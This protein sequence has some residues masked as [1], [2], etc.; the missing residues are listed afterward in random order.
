MKKKKN[1]KKSKKQTGRGN[2][3]HSYGPGIKIDEMARVGVQEYHAGYITRARQ[4]LENVLELK[5]D[6]LDA[7]HYLGLIAHAQEQY[8]R[9]IFLLD[10]AARHQPTNPLH[11]NNLAN[12]YAD[13]GRLDQAATCYKK[14]LELS[15]DTP[16]ILFNLANIRKA[17]GQLDKAEAAYMDLLNKDG[18]QIQA[19]LELAEIA[20]QSQNIDFA[21]AY[22]QPVVDEEP[23]NTAANSL[24]SRIRLLKGENGQP[25]ET[26]QNYPLEA[27][28]VPIYC[29]N[30]ILN[31]IYLDEYEAIQSL[32]Q[33]YPDAAISI[34][35]DLMNMIT[36]K[37]QGPLLAK[38]YAQ[39]IRGD[40]FT[41]TLQNTLLNKFLFYKL[42]QAAKKFGE[43]L[44]QAYPES[45]TMLNNVGIALLRQG[46]PQEAINYFEQALD[47]NP[48]HTQSLTNGAMALY[49]MRHHEASNAWYRKLITDNPDFIL[50]HSTFLLGLHYNP[51]VDKNTIY[52]EHLEWDQRHARALMPACNPRLKVKDNRENLKIGFTSGAFKRHPVGYFTLGLLENE[53]FQETVAVFIYS[54]TTAQDEFT[55]RLRNQP[56]AWRDTARLS[57]RDLAGLIRDDEIDILIDLS[58]HADGS[59]LLTFARHPAPVQAK[60]VGG[61]FNTTGMQAMDYFIT[62]WLESPEGE[63]GWFTETLVRLRDGYISYTPPAYAPEITL[64]PALRNRFITFGC[65]N[66][67]A[68]INEKVI[69]TWSIIL[70]LVPHSTLVLKSFQLNDPEVQNE[71]LE[72]FEAHGISRD[73]LE[74]RQASGHKELLRQYNDIDIAL[75]PFPYSGGLTTCEAMWMGVPV[76]TKPGETFA[77]RHAATHVT[78]VG[79]T[80]WVVNSEEEYIAKA[81]NWS[82]NLGQ[83]TKLRAGLREKVLNSPLCDHERFAQNF[84]ES[85][86]WMY[87]DTLQ[88]Q[89]KTSQNNEYMESQK[90]DNCA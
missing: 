63:E 32:V 76:L 3:T 22:L 44:L 27:T 38:S 46:K 77:A 37:D 88:R 31:H 48:E 15:P 10:L 16:E 75:D 7:L 82:K 17:M 43:S 23:D 39:A 45:E 12:V 58:G 9:A 73:R 25:N 80:D 71:L 86:W 26:A 62:D 67:I 40:S 51:N 66:N 24:L 52:Q 54:H 84:M 83:L 56:V 50:A 90:I 20:L 14:A 85:L 5:P 2:D 60:W 68:K 21:E 61:Q 34:F 29:T 42:F 41:P 55:N 70:K 11:F 78:N 72:Q 30:Q 64:L 28:D 59:R 89:E 57:D 79:L 19:R 49:E 18:L 8:N 87:E 47:I 6:H 69:S 36:S 81:V 74:L 1:R 13:R 4:I 35:D 65:F 33:T 53:T